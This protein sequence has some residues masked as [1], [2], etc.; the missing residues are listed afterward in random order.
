MNTVEKYQDILTP[1]ECIV[2]ISTDKACSPVNT[3]GICK[4]LS[5]KVMVEKSLTCKFKC[6]T[7]RYGNVIN[8]RGSIIPIL[9]EK[10]KDPQ[11]EEFTLTD[12]TI[13]RFIMTLEQSVD[14][15]EH[16]V[17][18]GQSGDIIIPKLI[19]M[20]ILDIFELFSEKYN[21]PIKITGLRP[22]EKILESLINETQSASMTKNNDYYYLKPS[23]KKIKSD[24]LICDYNSKLNPI[25][26]SQL[27]KLLEDY[28]LL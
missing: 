28:N 25:T 5:E 21:K 26:K 11:V 7:V 18:Y 8:S 6:M 22:G 24:E 17:V 23:Y 9:H 19:S 3:Y 13:T 4:A 20:K 10:G 16:A 2:F 27:K 12:N 14:L 1:L 15:I